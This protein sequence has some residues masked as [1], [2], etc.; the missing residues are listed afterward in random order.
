MQ[1]GGY[2][3]GYYS[4]QAEKKPLLTRIFGGSR[5]RAAI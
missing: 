2:G 5:N 4:E 1:Y 3:Y